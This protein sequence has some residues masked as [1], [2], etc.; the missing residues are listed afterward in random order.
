MPR[1]IRP[2]DLTDTERSRGIHALMISTFFSWAGFFL[3]IPLMAIHYVDHLGWAAGTLGIVL[4]LRQFSQ[5]GLTTLFGIICDRIGPKPLIS[6]GMLIRAGGFV[7]MAYAE[8]FWPVLI[9][10]LV[11]AFGGAMFEAPKSA[12]LATLATPETRQRI[13]S[14]IGVIGG[15]G[16]TVGTQLGALLIR[17][18]FAAVCLAGAVAFLLVALAIVIMMPPIGVSMSP[19]GSSIG[20]RHV[21]A[22][23]V[24]IFYLIILAGYWF[25]TTQF[26]LTILLAATDVAG[27]DSAVSWI[28]LVQASITVGLGYFLPRWLERWM[29]PL[30]LII[31][32]TAMIAA[33]LLAV[34]LAG[35]IIAI[36]VA[37]AVFSL[38]AV[39]ARPGQETV[40]ANLAD[41]AARGT[42]FGVAALSLAVGGGLGN[43]LGGVIY[44]FGTATT[45]V[46]P[47]V[48]Y[49]AVAAATALGMWLMRREF[50]VI[51]TEPV[52]PAPLSGEVKTARAH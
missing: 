32:G 41:P 46:L 10:A 24:F 23:R 27:T 16:T 2:T 39:L 4:A 20:M 21:F 49:A 40:T 31:A 45:P 44:D 26:G 5:Q 13:F 29:T 7:A 38:G 25:A 19:G 14:I 9:A 47:W 28:Y 30:Q 42:Y 36:L 48:V 50:G 15:I 1:T 12:S 37:V 43:Y 33:G 8:T 3:V 51:R 34:G 11:V 22:D 6:T 52:V 35:N 17:A 18:D